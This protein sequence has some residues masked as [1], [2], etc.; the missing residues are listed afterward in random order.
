[1]KALRN[2]DFSSQR[3][4]NATEDKKRFAALDLKF[5]FYVAAASENLLLFDLVSTIRNQL[6][7]TINRVLPL[8]NA[9]PLSLKEHMTIVDAI[10]RR[11]PEK[12]REA[13][14]HHL[15]ATL[16][17]YR[18]ALGTQRVSTAVLSKKNSS[19]RRNQTAKAD[20]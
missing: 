20:T 3:W 7:K 2:C 19:G 16:K 13:M 12:A 17:R 6:E 11:N 4:K 8:P 10:A 5:H 18:R 14:Q 1:M 15:N 9:M